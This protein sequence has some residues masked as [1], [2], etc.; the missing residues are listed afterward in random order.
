MNFLQKSSFKKLLVI[1][2]TIL[3]FI[4]FSSVQKKST[5]RNASLSHLFYSLRD[6]GEKNLKEGNFQL[7]IK[8]FQQAL[9]LAR[10][11]EHNIEEIK[12][13]MDL[14]LLYWNIGQL[15]ESSD[16]YIKALLLEKRFNLNNE[17]EKCRKVLEIY[18]F[19]TEGK[20]YRSSGQYQNSIESFEKAILLAR[21][22]GSK[23]HEVKCLRQ[24]SATYWEVNNLQRFFNLNNEALKIAQELNHKKEEWRCLNNIGLFYKKLDYYSKALSFYEN[25]LK[26]VR[27]ENEKESTALLLNNI[28]VVYQELGAYDKAI[29][30][31]KKALKID[32]QLGM[33]VYVA[34][35]LSNLGETFRSKALISGDKEDFYTGLDYFNKGLGLIRKTGDKRTEIQV[36]NNIGTVHSDL[37][38]YHEALLYFQAGYKNAEEI[39]D[40][41]A[42]GMILNNMG[43]V[44]FSRGNYKK[45]IISI[46]KAVEI[47]SSL[48]FNQILWEA[49]FWLGRCYEKNNHFSQA[50]TFYHEAIEV[51][52]N[53][54]SQIFLDSYKAGFVRDK[55]KVYEF[56]IDLLYRLHMDNPSN[57]FGKEI[58]HIVE[59]AKARAFLE[60]LKESRIDIR[61]RLSPELKK[62]EKDIAGQISSII[63]NLSQG[64]L[65]E[66]K[67]NELIRRLK[68]KEHGYIELISKMRVEI[69]EVAKLVSPEPCR[70][71]KVQEQLIDEKTALI[72]YFLGGNRSLMLFVTKNEFNL[73]SLPPR[74]S[75]EK[76]IRAYLKIL[77]QPPKG[78]FKG[79][80]AAQRIYKELLSLSEKNIPE[81]V[82]NLIIIPDGILY[83]LPFETLISSAR[84]KS[85]E[86]KYLIG[87]YKISYAPSSSS[88]LFLS[89]EEREKGTSKGLL[90][91]GNPFYNTKASLKR[92]KNKTYSQV[93]KELYTSQGFECSPLPYSKKEIKKISEFFSKNKRN[94]YLEKKA[95]EDVVK[96]ISLNDYQVIHFACHSFLDEKFP[97]RSALV[98]ALDD[99]M[100][101]DGF[102]QVREIYNLRMRADL[103]VLSACQTG[104]GKLEI[105]EGILG[106]PRIFF[107][108][109]AKS[110]VSTLWKVN[111]K[112]T[113]MFMSYFYRYL[114]QGNNKTQAMQLAKLRMIKS[115]VS[116]PFY[117]GAFV[118]NGDYSSRLNFK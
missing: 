116:H 88:L 23:E 84:R 93:L 104:K 81:S 112:A 39:Q 69:P 4:S 49:Y 115:K 15:R 95:K 94:I 60:S 52:D 41:E 108:A 37:K 29:E 8:A 70:M 72:E 86:E 3:I 59:R 77:S 96:K 92:K 68:Q 18:R 82:D 76:S 51:I 22:I 7:A 17:E 2:F 42:I 117:W 62:S 38:N 66:K 67:R 27:L 105:G 103:I 47:S 34:M 13:L 54:R 46:H 106:L 98:L 32:K 85:L 118:L 1:S 48:Q 111:D 40:V 65:S 71:E 26:I 113:A 102:L 109:G 73:F 58:F 20:K 114:S 89:E 75:I 25:A 78:K 19:Y 64:N 35:G 16:T 6:S 63:M 55:L 110:V 21:K 99:D 33:D 5:D 44:H 90:A 57:G 24:L 30:C 10:E 31:L 107:Y 61:E 14:G 36:L 12:C 43:I 50:L 100:D 11:F 28:G 79:I 87:E 56:L 80:L 45:A 97:F 91:F 74:E 101:E 9:V 53:I 83:Y